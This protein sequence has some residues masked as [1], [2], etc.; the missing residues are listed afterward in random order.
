MSVLVLVLVLVL[1]L[2]LKLVLVL[3]LV[4]MLML[5]LVVYLRRR[6]PRLQLNRVSN[7]QARILMMLHTLD[8]LFLIPT[9]L[10]Y[11][12]AVLQQHQRPHLIELLDVQRMRHFR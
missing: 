11:L 9:V 6:L 4:L 3:M 1:M 12:V 5:M 2:V 8:T 10:R 7:L